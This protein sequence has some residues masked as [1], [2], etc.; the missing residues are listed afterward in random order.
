MTIHPMTVVLASLREIA[1]PVETDERLDDSATIATLRTVLR[2]HA[3]IAGHAEGL[4]L[5][6]LSRLAGPE[7]YAR[8]PAFSDAFVGMQFRNAVGEESASELLPAVGS[9]SQ[10]TCVRCGWRMG[11]SPLNCQNDNTPHVFPSQQA[12]LREVAEKADMVIA[13]VKQAASA[14]V[15]LLNSMVESGEVHTS[16]SREV[17]ASFRQAMT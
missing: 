4:L 14:T 8:D 11:S 3:E 6:Q 17:V 16:K 5:G 15:G 7:G 13:A 12:A 1:V 9:C 10:E 2:R